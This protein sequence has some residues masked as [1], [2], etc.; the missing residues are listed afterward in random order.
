MIEAICS[1]CVLFCPFYSLKPKY[2]YFSSRRRR[3][4]AWTLFL[5]FVIEIAIFVLGFMILGDILHSILNKK[6]A[7]IAI[8]L[9]SIALVTALYRLENFSNYLKEQDKK[10]IR[11]KIDHEIFK[12]KAS[13]IDVVD[14]LITLKKE[15]EVVKR[16]LEDSKEPILTVNLVNTAL[17]VIGGYYLANIKSY[18]KVG[19][20]PLI[21]L[22]IIF[23]ILYSYLT[24]EI[25]K[26]SKLY[27]LELY[28]YQISYAN[29]LIERYRK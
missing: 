18:E 15:N 16:T 1:L 13:K 4:Y 19:V 28:N 22:L 6:L 24:L 11:E 2:I 10:E 3:L 12:I 29:R 25:T 27:L 26:T 21:F 14:F 20:S 23:A 8:V 17:G 9:L 5:L 7:F